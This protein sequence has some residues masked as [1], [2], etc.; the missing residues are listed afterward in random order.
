MKRILAAI[1]AALLIAFAI[2]SAEQVTIIGNVECAPVTG[3]EVLLTESLQPRASDTPERTYRPLPTY[4]PLPTPEPTKEPGRLAGLII[5]IDPGH[6]AHANNDKEAVAPNSKEKKAKVSSGTSG[7]ST[8][9]AEYVAN[10]EVGLQLREA[11]EALDAT[12]I[13]TREVHEI[14]ISN[15]ERAFM[16][17]E[18]NADLV[19]RIHCDGANDRSAH[20]TAMYV[21]KTG[22]RQAECEAAANVLLDEM[23]AVTGAKKRGVFLRDTY[24]MNNWSTVPCILVEMGFMSNREEDEKLND[25]AYQ[26]L[27]VEG[28]VNGICAYFER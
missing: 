13:M 8:G 20:G 25:P 9:V 16:M 27:L 24:T 14:D 28:M 18:A 6:Q 19:L 21:R 1:L 17:N 10:L 2:T 23:C 11:L 3:D 22:E 4:A 7:A 5:G 15:Q 12:V 26:D